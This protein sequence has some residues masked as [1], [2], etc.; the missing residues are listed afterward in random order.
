MSMNFNRGL[1]AVAEGVERVV[2]FDMV[3]KKIWANLQYSFHF[4]DYQ[5]EGDVERG[6][7]LQ[8]TVVIRVHYVEYGLWLERSPPVFLFRAV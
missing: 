5:T 8:I 2:L 4:A 6:I 3:V 7:S 1:G